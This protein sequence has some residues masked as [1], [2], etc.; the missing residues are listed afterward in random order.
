MP[1]SARER[2]APRHVPLRHSLTLLGVTAWALIVSTELVSAL[3]LSA[4][5][6]GADFETAYWAAASNVATGRSPYEWLAA[7]RPQDA[8]EYVYPPLL[9]LLLAPFTWML[10]YPTALGAWLVF[11]TLSLV[12]GI[13]LVWQ[14]SGLRSGPPSALPLL[15]FLPLAP[16][17]IGGIG[18]GRVS[19]QLLLVIA[20]GYAALSLGHSVRAGALLACGAYLKSFPALLGGYLLLRR[21]WVAASVAL[22]VG[23][24]LLLLTAL[25]LGWEDLWTYLTGVLPAQRHLFGIPANVSITGFFTRLLIPNPFTTP[26]IAAEVPAQVVIAGSMAAILVATGYAVWRAPPD[27]DA[28]TTAYGLAV[29]ASMLLAPIN[30]IDHLTIAALPVSILGARVQ[31]V[32]PRYGGW[33][34]LTMVFLS[35]PA[36]FYDFWPV[37]YVYLTTLPAVSPGQWP[38]RVGWGTLLAAGPFLGLLLLWALLFRLC[39]ERFAATAPAG[40]PQR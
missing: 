34:V 17:I 2:A 15:L 5:H 24:G 6:L 10:D 27:R 38:W 9:A 12:L 22:V 29:T 23:L 7:N 28:E 36:D 35:L 40:G 18:W 16:A 31:A 25:I 14:I 37:Q 32:W 33:L 4:R 19:T 8:T 20:A 1:E 3:G 30:S 21:R 13:I 11:S 26:V 39:L